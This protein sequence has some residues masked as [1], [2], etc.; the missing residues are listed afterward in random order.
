VNSPID[1]SRHSGQKLKLVVVGINW[2]SV[3]N[4]FDLLHCQKALC[5]PSGWS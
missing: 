3:Q 1:T 4:N 5:F 2:G